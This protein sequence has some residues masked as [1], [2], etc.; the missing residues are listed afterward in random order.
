METRPQSRKIGTLS[1]SDIIFLISSFFG[2]NPRARIATFSSLA[3]M[4]PDPSVSKR[5]KASLIS[6]FCS[7]VN[8]NF[9]LLDPP[10]FFDY[11]KKWMLDE[12]ADGSLSKHIYSFALKSWCDRRR[13]GEKGKHSS[14][15]RI[16]EVSTVRGRNKN[17]KKGEEKGRVSS[18]QDAPQLHH[19]LTMVLGEVSPRKAAA[20]DCAVNPHF[21]TTIKWFEIRFQQAV[22]PP[23]ERQTA[24]PL[25][26]SPTRRFLWMYE[27]SRIHTTWTHEH[28]AWTK[29]EY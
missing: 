13:S 18:G 3:S 8:S 24:L 7:S 19:V 12:K 11:G 16:Q 29:S 17:W 28:H 2:S 21:Q 1:I 6:C 26:C 10:A 23:T 27:Y 25:L 22:S 9:L 20:I 14:S 15:L 5:S 4:V